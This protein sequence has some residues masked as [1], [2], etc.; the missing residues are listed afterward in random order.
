MIDSDKKVW[1]IEVNE[2]PC[3]ECS[4]P[5]LAALIPQMV[6][7]ALQLTADSIFRPQKSDDSEGGSDRKGWEMLGKLNANCQYR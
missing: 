2:N 4:S 6:N 3:L 1:L 7:G 5:L